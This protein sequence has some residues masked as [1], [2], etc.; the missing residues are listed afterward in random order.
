LTQKNFGWRVLKNGFPPG[1]GKKIAHRLADRDDGAA[2]FPIGPK[3]FG[4][5]LAE[6][7]FLSSA[8]ASSM[9]R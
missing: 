9:K 1:D 5:Y 8:H 6:A 3:R 7:S 4:K 2:K